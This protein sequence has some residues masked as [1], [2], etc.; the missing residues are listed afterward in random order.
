LVD[1]LPLEAVVHKET[2][3]D[4]SAEDISR[5]YA[6]KESLPENRKFVEENG[7][8][9]LAQVFTDVRYTKEDNEL[10]SGMLLDVLRQQGFLNEKL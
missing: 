10:F 7:K 3:Q 9:T 2:Y 8:E 6:E 1:R 5:L 4:Y